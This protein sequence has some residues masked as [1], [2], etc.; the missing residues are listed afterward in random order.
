M[1]HADPDVLIIGAGVAGAVAAK[2]L[3]EAGMRVV[4][5]E[6]G[7]WPDRALALMALPE[8]E[9]SSIGPSAWNPNHRNGEA[10]YPIGD[11][12]S[13][14]SPLMYNGVGGGTVLYGAQWGRNA[15]SD[16]RVRT[17]DGV[18]DDWP[19]SYEELLPYYAR[20]DRDFGVSGLA[21]DPAYP[22]SGEALPLPPLPLGEMGRRVA[23]AHNELGW[24]WWPHPTAIGIRRNGGLGVCGQGPACRR[25]CVE[26]A[27]THQTHWPVA[28]A[29]G[30][31]LITGARVRGLV[32]NERGL[33]AGAVYVDRGG[34]ERLQKAPVTL[35]AANAVGSARLLLLSA[36]AHH[37]D[38]LANGSGLVGK[39][40]MMHP[41]GTVAGIF[42]DDVD[43]ARGTR[44]IPLHSRQFYE[45]DTSRGFVR[46]A[47]WG[48][49]PTGGPLTCSAGHAWGQ[50]NE[51]FGPGFQD[52]VRRRF[53]HSTMWGI[54][55]EDLPDVH[56][57]VEL[58]PNLVDSDG[59]PAP[60]IIYRI[61]ENSKRLIEFH[62][63]RAAESLQAAGATQ[64]I[65]GGFSRDTGWHL[66]G[67]AV[68]GTDPDTSVV[69]PYGC[70]HEVRNLY[71]IDGSTWPTSGGTNPSATVAALA[72]RTSEWMLREHR[73]QKVAG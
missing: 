31:R 14:I 32:L 58:H 51:I 73:N 38:G 8:V 43:S 64:V 20:I 22:P 3:A 56:N 60:K 26:V 53:G 10:D 66:L 24:H 11:E 5:L 19:L 29:R 7:G 2:R 30:A 23:R 55:G 40:L 67:T 33:V 70:A 27:R 15:P 42:P 28:I 18:G 9:W 61:S 57:R 12:E 69:D 6:Q 52:I 16:F 65:C 35:L 36:Q 13:D 25:G 48:L 68:M 39:R 72:L 45:T 54:I 50:H 47:K 63:R 4:C 21:G 34:Q 49:H 41:H 44:G 37:P 46:G 71:I 1:T 62:M 17:L 59:V